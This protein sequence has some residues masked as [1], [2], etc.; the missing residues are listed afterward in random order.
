MDCPKCKK[1]LIVE[2]RFTHCDDENKVDVQL[3]C[4]GCEYSAFTFLGVEDFIETE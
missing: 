1:E 4:T 2:A 3:H